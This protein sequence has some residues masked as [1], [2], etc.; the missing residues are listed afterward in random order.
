MRHRSRDM[1]L[2]GE[3]RETKKMN[4]HTYRRTSYIQTDTR[5]P[6]HT[7]TC[8]HRHTHTYTYIH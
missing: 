7:H 6:T 1:N 8:M 2:A 3:K 5:M 4:T